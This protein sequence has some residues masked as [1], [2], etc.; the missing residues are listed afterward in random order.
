MRH[1][2]SARLVSRKRTGDFERY[3]TGGHGRAA[4]TPPARAFRA[5]ATSS[6]G[7]LLGAV[8]IDHFAFLPTLEFAKI[9]IQGPVLGGLFAVA[10]YLMAERAVQ[11][12]GLPPTPAVATESRLIQPLYEKPFELSTLAALVERVRSES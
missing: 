6:F 7:Y 9:T 3:R 5:V 10:A 11:R 4:G 1:P 2:P 12:L 8:Q